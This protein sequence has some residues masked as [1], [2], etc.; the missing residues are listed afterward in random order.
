MLSK[1]TVL[2]N[3][4]DSDT[5][6]DLDTGSTAGEIAEVLKRCGYTVE[7]K[8]IHQNEIDQVRHLDCDLVFNLVEW[9]GTHCDSGVRVT[10][11]LEESGI[12]FTGS[13][14]KGYDLSCRKEVMKKLFRQNRIP[15][16]K[17]FIAE[18]A[19]MKLPDRFPYPAMVKPTWEHCG[20]GVT[21]ESIVSG[22]RN[23]RKKIAQMLEQYHQPILVEEYVE[24]RELHVTVFE[25]N[26]RL[27]V[28]P[29]TEIVFDK[30][31]GYVP[32]LTYDSKWNE[33]A[34]EYDMSRVVT[35]ELDPKLLSNI[36]RLARKC[37]RVLDGRDY[38]RLD[39]RVRDSKPYV[40]EI[41]NN[42]GID[43]E[44][45]SGI[46]RSA[47]AAGMTFE[48]MTASIAENAYKRWLNSRR[49]DTATA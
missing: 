18:S 7:L 39:I 12:A 48:T 23:L 46:G 11:A 15:T 8:G 41:N 21:Q 6:E 13:G 45:N 34:W 47:M 16:P 17:W 44:P 37:A 20:V 2:Y 43:F 24:G 14:S 4:P 36:N 40:L 26:G 31:E 32:I 25:R 10:R 38:P 28:L 9:T 30:K 42:P 5:A 3:L 19:D 33:Q 29:P 1:I 35:A 27:W 22:K 49:Y